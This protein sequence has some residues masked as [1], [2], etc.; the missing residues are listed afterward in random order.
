MIRI[1]GLLVWTVVVLLPACVT[2]RQTAYRAP[3]ALDS[4][5]VMTAS[6][7]AVMGAAPFAHPGGPTNQVCFR[8]TVE[9]RSSASDPALAG[10]I[11]QL[12]ASFETSQ[13]RIIPQC[14]FGNGG[15]YGG[16]MVAADGQPA[17]F[18]KIQTPR[19]ITPDSAEIGI[20]ERRGGRWGGGHLC[21]LRKLPRFNWAVSGCRGLFVS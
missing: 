17:I 21:T 20:E 10:L 15:S 5:S 7:K 4:L 18:V 1:C 9:G 14:T 12:S 16:W 13:I 3:A 11:V 19:F 8:T 6:F 2:N